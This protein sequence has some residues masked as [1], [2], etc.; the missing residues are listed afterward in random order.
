MKQYEK[1]ADETMIKWIRGGDSKAMDDL[2]RKYTS[3]VKKEARK[4]YLIGADEEDLIQEGMIGLFQAIRDFEEGQGN[5]FS[6]FAFM[7]IRRQMYTAI[8][9]SNRKKHQ[10]LNSYISFDEPAFLEEP[11]KTLE[12]TISADEKNTNPEQIVLD[13][14]QADM[15]ESVIVERLSSYEKKVLHLFLEGYSYD[16]IA[17]QLHKSRKSVDN[18]IQ[19]IR[20]KFNSL[21]Q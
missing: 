18:A 7:C 16:H 5:S 11:E 15:I 2:L 3:T 10:P 9:A 14:E 8:T 21:N 4:M 6:S 1:A 19:R 20:R 17:Q 13:K 12:D